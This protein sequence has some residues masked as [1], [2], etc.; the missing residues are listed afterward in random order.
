MK[1]S[2]EGGNAEEEEGREERECDRADDEMIVHAKMV[3]LRWGKLKPLINLECVQ[4]ELQGD[5]CT[6]RVDL[7][8]SFAF[9]P[10]QTKGSP[11]ASPGRDFPP[12]QV[13][14]H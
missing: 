4:D 13:A 11:E 14:P 6:Y 2:K 3:F 5:E 8:H 9:I 12:P 7:M 1:P 10:C